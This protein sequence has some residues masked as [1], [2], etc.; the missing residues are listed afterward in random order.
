V[1]DLAGTDPERQKAELARVAGF[2]LRKHLSA[3]D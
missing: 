3:E 2:V 1:R